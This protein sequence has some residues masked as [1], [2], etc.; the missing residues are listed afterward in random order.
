MYDLCIFI[1][2]KLDI[3]IAALKS[4]G[5]FF[6]KYI[7]YKISGI[8][9]FYFFYSKEQP[10]KHD[11]FFSNSEK[12][13]ENHENL[14]LNFKQ[15]MH[16]F[17]YDYDKISKNFNFSEQVEIIFKRFERV[18]YYLLKK[19]KFTFMYLKNII[20]LETLQYFYY[21]KLETDSDDKKFNDYWYNQ[22]FK[23][24]NKNVFRSFILYKVI[25]VINL[26]LTFF[27]FFKNFILAAVIFVT[28]IYF[29]FYLYTL[30]FFKTFAVYLLIGF[31][32]FWLFSTF[33]F[34]IK[35]YKYSKYTSA[36]QRF[37]KR[38]FMCFW[39]IEGFL[40]SIFFYYLINA[41]SEPFFIYDTYG[42]YIN[43]LNTLKIFL[44]NSF[45][46]VLLLNLFIFALINIKFTSLKK[47]SYLFLFITFIY[48]Y[49]LMTEFYQFYYLL[50]FYSDY[51][52]NF[53]EDENVWEL[54]YDIPRTRTKNHY[55]TL[56]MLAKFW[57]YLFV[58][59]SWMF[60]LVKTVELNR[61]RYAFLSMNFQNTILFYI[62]NWLCL[63]SWFKWIFRRFFDQTYYWFFTSFRPLSLNIT[64]ND[65]IVYTKNIVSY[66][67][68]FLKN[69][70]NY[71]F[72]YFFISNKSFYGQSSYFKLY[73]KSAFLH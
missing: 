12:F 57:H 51:I 38:A 28:I 44:T 8:V 61:I 48:V 4:Y 54:D 25:S 29:F 27:V 35:R 9:Y 50:N 10:F 52:W 62:M 45:L 40:F 65:I 63:Y 5:Y 56:L 37:W 46:I 11:N 69:N 34:F 58:F 36:I 55:V 39:L 20:D 19:L 22:Y 18:Y 7:I 73:I 14:F 31:L 30:T 23:K 49:I 64:V 68:K 67:L 13:A 32:F 72:V 47:N 43:S 16:Y 59:I 21:K 3:K 42:L 71:N 6:E 24:F 53:S 60:F 15:S 66:N 33:N 41:S 17:Y 26:P 70:Y 1:K 2:N